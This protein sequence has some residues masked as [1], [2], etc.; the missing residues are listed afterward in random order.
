[1]RKVKVLAVGC[2]HDE[3]HTKSIGTE[4]LL[5]VFRDDFIPQAFTHFASVNGSDHPV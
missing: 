5:V 4:L 2:A 1:M 3:T